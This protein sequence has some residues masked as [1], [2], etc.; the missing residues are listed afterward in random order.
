MARAPGK[1]DACM[2]V[3]VIGGGLLA[4]IAYLLSEAVRWLA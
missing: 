2:V 4:G 3:L 1:K